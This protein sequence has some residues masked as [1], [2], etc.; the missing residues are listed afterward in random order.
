MPVMRFMSKEMDI[1]KVH[2]KSQ[3]FKGLYLIKKLSKRS[4]YVPFINNSGPTPKEGGSSQSPLQSYR[5]ENLSHMPSWP[6]NYPHKDSAMQRLSVLRDTSY[7]WKLMFQLPEDEARGGLRW[8]GNLICVVLFSL[9]P[10]L[11]FLV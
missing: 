9:H 8:E 4:P 5:G 3:F 1:K 10:P 6:F 2:T 7:K 11:H